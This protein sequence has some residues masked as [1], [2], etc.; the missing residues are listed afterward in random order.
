ML[1]APATSKSV[2]FRVVSEEQY[3][4]ELIFSV[5]DDDQPNKQLVSVEVYAD[6]KERK[7]YARQLLYFT[8]LVERG[9]KSGMPRRVRLLP[10]LLRATHRH[11]RS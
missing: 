2:S 1:S 7:L 9:T 4:E 10:F 5:G 11:G 8:D 6:A 3:P